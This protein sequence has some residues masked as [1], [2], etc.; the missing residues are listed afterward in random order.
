MNPTRALDYAR[1]HQARF[2]AELRE[3]VRFPTV[4]SQPQHAGNIRRCA[5]W[6]VK[7]LA[8]I[9]LDAVRIVPTTRHPVVYAE[10]LRRPGAPTVLIYGHYD[11]QP[12][13][14]LAEWTSPPFEP[15]IRGSDLY[16]RGACDDKGQLFVHVKAMEAWLRTEGALPVNVKCIFEGEEE[17]GSPH[18]ARLIARNRSALQAGVALISDT[19]MLAKDRPALSCSQRGTLSVEWEVSG[20]KHDLHSGNFGGAIHNPLQALCEM[21]ASLHDARGR[22]S[23]PGFYARVRRW[24]PAERASMRRSGP[25]DRGILRDAQTAHGWGERGYTL[26]E[27]TTLRPALTL[28]G[29]T[30]GYGGPGVKA[31]IPARALAKLNFRLVVDQDPREIEE[32]FRRHVARITPPTVRSTVRTVSRASP[33]LIDPR[34][35]AMRAA[36]IAYRKAFGRAPALIRS[37]GTIPAVS[38]FQKDLGIPSV[39]MGFA[40]PDS[41]IHAPNERFHLP[42][43]RRGIDASIWFL[44]ALGAMAGSL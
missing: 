17:I 3:F 33:A 28:N 31:V 7:Q 36:A 10:W 23:I 40:L 5:A 43:F 8:G 37:G 35:P 4:S 15:A 24:S 27:R 32:L 1:A 38:L 18:L 6:L 16:G 19:R 25:S 2:T 26:Y 44:H 9:G 41:R 42:N 21:L 13:D 34:H 14:P 29:I 11:V 12:A 20:P 30:G 39:L 22:V